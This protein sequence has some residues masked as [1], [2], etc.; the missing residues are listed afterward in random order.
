MVRFAF[1]SEIP[2]SIMAQFLW[3]TDAVGSS[4]NSISGSIIRA[5]GKAN[6][7]R[8]TARRKQ[9]GRLITLMRQ[10][11]KIKGLQIAADPFTLPDTVL[12]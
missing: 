10:T 4:R 2:S 11:N 1:I 12:C 9:K 3:S 5:R 8:F 7:P 6:A